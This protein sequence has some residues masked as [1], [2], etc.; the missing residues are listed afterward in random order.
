MERE[1]GGLAGVKGKRRRRASR[2]DGIA[3][4]YARQPVQQTLVQALQGEAL[5]V[6]F[7]PAGREPSPIWPGGH[8][9]HRQ[10]QR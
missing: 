6:R 7:R 3:A 10:R 2:S 4:L 9:A 1:L 5:T 8:L